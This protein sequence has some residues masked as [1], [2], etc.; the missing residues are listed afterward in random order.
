MFTVRQHNGDRING[1]ASTGDAGDAGD[2]HDGWTLRINKP[3]LHGHAR[4]GS[5]KRRY[6]RTRNKRQM[7]FVL[8]SFFTSRRC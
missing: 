2:G 3:F 6:W 7:E 4:T 1:R 8:D 5:E